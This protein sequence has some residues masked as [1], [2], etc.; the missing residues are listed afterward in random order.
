M[1]PICSVLPNTIYAPINKVQY[2]M[3]AYHTHPPTARQQYRTCRL[4]AT[5]HDQGALMPRQ[6]MYL[7]VGSCCCSMTLSIVKTPLIY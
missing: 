2:V 5:A 3:V 6:I 7:L 1:R 4:N